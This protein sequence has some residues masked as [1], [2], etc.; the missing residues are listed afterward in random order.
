MPAETPRPNLLK[1]PSEKLQRL[2]VEKRKYR[3]VHLH[4]GV[5]R[6]SHYPHPTLRLL[7]ILR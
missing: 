4:Q 5:T 7:Q 1:R 3:T 6:M 2:L